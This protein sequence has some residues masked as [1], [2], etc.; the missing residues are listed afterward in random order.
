M[1]LLSLAPVSRPNSRL[2]TLLANTCDALQK[3]QQLGLLD[4]DFEALERLQEAL[5][6][7]FAAQLS[8][9]QWM[10]FLAQFG[11]TMLGL[12]GPVGPCLRRPLPWCCCMCTP[13]V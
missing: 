9:P 4:C 3:K 7:E 12:V 13:M 5:G 6:P 1:Q 2:R 8:A 10:R 11:A